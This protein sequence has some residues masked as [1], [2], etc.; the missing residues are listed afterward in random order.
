[1]KRSLVVLAATGL[2]GLAGCYWT[3]QSDIAGQPFAYRTGS[4]VVESVTPA[5]KPFAAAAGGSASASPYEPT[6]YRLAIRMDDGRLQYLDT[7]ST[8]FTRGTLVRLRDE[9]LIEKQ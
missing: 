1:M 2:A 7:E 6:L 4:G 9:R 8:E 3:P 5:P